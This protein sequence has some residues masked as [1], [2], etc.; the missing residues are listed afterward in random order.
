[1]ARSLAVSAPGIS[2]RRYCARSPRACAAASC[3]AGAAELLIGEPIRPSSSGCAGIAGASRLSSATLIAAV[4]ACIS[5]LPVD[6][7][8]RETRRRHPLLLWLLHYLLY[9]RQSPTRRF[10]LRFP[11]P[12]PCAAASCSAQGRGKGKRKT[13]RRVGD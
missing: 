2:I 5:N 7:V 3:I 4:A 6:A 12:R 10:V 9:F 13:K 1:M 8:G 11:L